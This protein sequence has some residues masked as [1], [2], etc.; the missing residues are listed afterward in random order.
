[1]NIILITVAL[2]EVIPFGYMM[3]IMLIKLVK[4]LTNTV[5]KVLDRCV[6]DIPYRN[7]IASA[8]FFFQDMGP[9]ISSFSIIAMFISSEEN[10]VTLTIVFIVG[11]IIKELSRKLKNAFY[12]EINVRSS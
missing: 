6:H 12:N 3:Y 11:I 10:Y 1:M 9:N 2:V 5:N 7:N 4:G 8:L